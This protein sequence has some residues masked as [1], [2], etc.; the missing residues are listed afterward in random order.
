MAYKGTHHR[1]VCLNEWIAFGN[2]K[3]GEHSGFSVVKIP[4]N[5]TQAA[6]ATSEY[7]TGFDLQA[8]WV[9]FDAWIVVNT[10]DATET[11]NVGTNSNDSG[12]ADGLIVGA[13]LGT[14]GFVY[15]D[16]TVTAGTTYSY[17]SANTRG[18]LLADY[19]VGANGAGTEG[20]YHPKPYNVGTTAIDVTFTT[21][22]GTDT[23]VFDIYLMIYDPT[24]AASIDTYSKET[25]AVAS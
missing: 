8:G 25:M 1:S 4:V 18:A 2:K 14:A 21:S 17:F 3:E 9:V 15:P 20:L 12:D 5:A 16:G 11:V 19:K 22:A 13:S 23:A 7:D 6:A 24:P 10:I